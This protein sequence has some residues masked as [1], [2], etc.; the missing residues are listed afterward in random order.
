MDQYRQGA[1]EMLDINK[2]YYIEE[3][4]E[5]SLNARYDEINEMRTLQLSLIS[6]RNKLFSGLLITPVISIILRKKPD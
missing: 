6:F 1:T 4:G 3:L 5:E 2:S